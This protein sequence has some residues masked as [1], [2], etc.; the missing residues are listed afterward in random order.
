MIEY[1]GLSNQTITATPGSE[2]IRFVGCENCKVEGIEQSAIHYGNMLAID[3]CKDMEFIEPKARN[4][5]LAVWTPGAQLTGIGIDGSPENGVYS[6]N[7]R[8]Y[9]PRIEALSITSQA[10]AGLGGKF[11]TDGINIA[12]AQT[13]GVYIEDPF[14]RGVGEGI[15]NFGKYT[16]IKGGEILEAYTMGIK[17]IHGPQFGLVYETVIRGVGLHGVAIFG[18]NQAAADALYNQFIGIYVGVC[19][20][21]ANYSAADFSAFAALFPSGCTTKPAQ[22]VF[23]GCSSDMSAK[24]DLLT[25]CPSGS[26]NKFLRMGNRRTANTYNSEG[27]TVT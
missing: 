21:G 26:G 1:R 6:Q 24:W 7:I 23:D 15:D 4:G 5:T 12:A 2:P 17:W 16:V 19:N 25:N 22:T 18:S 3:S 13:R 9:K 27:A 10:F 14:I 11:E 20:W 8:I